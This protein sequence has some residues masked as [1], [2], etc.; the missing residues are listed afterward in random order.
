VAKVGCALAHLGRH[1][2]ARELLAELERRVADEPIST[3]AIATLHLH[4]G[5]RDAFYHWAKRSIDECDPFAMAIN[6]ERLWDPAR[7]E[8]GFGELVR[9]VGLLS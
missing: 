5:D 6:R 3:A 1:A 8:P 7:D 2:E 4:L 9:R